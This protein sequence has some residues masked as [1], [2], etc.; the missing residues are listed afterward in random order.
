MREFLSYFSLDSYRA[1][2]VC[3]MAVL[4]TG[5]SVNY[6]IHVLVFVSVCCGSPQTSQT[7]RSIVPEEFVSARPAARTGPAKH[8]SA[9]QQPSKPTMLGLTIWQLRMPRAGDSGTRL[10]VHTVSGSEEWIPERVSANSPLRSGSRVRLALESAKQGYLYVIDREEY[11][12]G[13]TGEPVVIFPTRRIRG[14]NNYVVPGRL[15]EIP[16]REDEPS[17]LTVEPSRAGQKGELLTVIVAHQPIKEIPILEQGD[18][19]SSDLLSKWEKQWAAAAETFESA[20]RQYWSLAESE[21]GA[22]AKRL[23]TRSEPEPQAVYRVSNRV[24]GVFLV[25]IRLR[26][27]N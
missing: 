4:C 11:A 14:G 24:P 26:Y 13:K 12:D 6:K 22:N 25:N 21:A 16:A 17:Y 18:T 19:I 3:R 20:N 10:L 23:L 2:S 27:G 7:T 1:G 15:I 8:V 5:E 9:E